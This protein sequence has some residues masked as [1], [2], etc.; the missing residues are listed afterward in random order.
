MVTQLTEKIY[1]LAQYLE[2]ETTA[3]LHHEFINGEI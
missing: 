2:L 3:E 1:T